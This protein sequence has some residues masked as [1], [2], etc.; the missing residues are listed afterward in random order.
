MKKS[1][2]KTYAWT[3]LLGLL[4]ALTIVVG[5]RTAAI[6]EVKVGDF[7]D[8]SNAQKIQGL[9]PD[10]VYDYVKKG[11]ITMKIGK[12]NYDPRD[13]GTAD[14][15]EYLKK[16]AGRYSMNTK[17][18]FID[19]KTGEV[20]PMDLI[21]V[22]FPTIDVKDPMCGLM[23][24]HNHMIYLNLRSNTL[25]YTAL[26]FIGKKM[27]RYINGPSISMVTVGTKANNAQQAEADMFGKKV[28]SLFS[29]K[30]T[31]PYELNGLATMTYQYSD[32]TPDKVFA[33][34]PALRRARVLTAGSRSD[35]MY[36]SDLSLDDA[37][38]GFMGKARDFN[39]KYLRTQDALSRFYG[40]DVMGVE[41]QANGTYELVKNRKNTLWG[42]ETPGW[43]GKPWATTNDIW[44]IRKVHIIE[45]SSKDPYYGYGKFELWYDPETYQ[46]AFKVIWDKAGKRWKI[47][48]AGQ[49]AYD[50]GDGVIGK[51]EAGF[52]DWIY[53][54]QRDHG[55][56]LDSFG[57]KYGRP[58][59]NMYGKIHATDFTMSGFA[60]FSK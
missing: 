29:M 13:M 6:A 59:Y 52:C 34:V 5:S 37:S 53:D 51:N 15:K 32:N 33:Y 44:V 16:N 47:E 38:G 21:G 58:I 10:V 55:T 36:G 56:G 18:E 11:W 17:G 49:G 45:C 8:A 1:T 28:Q 19:K 20:D 60:K 23:M 30:V 24:L 42:Y 39:C 4:M 46:F 22:P 40:P 14:Y 48:N 3:I 43:K 50:A 57:T 2:T 54:E 27:E 12:L 35:A 25:S 31:D 7:I 41:K 9:V 26:L